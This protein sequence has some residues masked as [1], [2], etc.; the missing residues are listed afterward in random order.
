MK[1]KAKYRIVPVCSGSCGYVQYHVQKRTWLG[2]TQIGWK[3]S[4]DGAE[5]LVKELL[6]EIQYYY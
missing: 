4:K 6:S 3:P 1:K 5:I 2:W